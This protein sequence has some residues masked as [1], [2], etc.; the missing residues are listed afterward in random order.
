MFQNRLVSSD[1]SGHILQRGRSAG[2]WS[3]AGVAVVPSPGVATVAD[4]VA[5]NDD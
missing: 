4:D 2:D 1:K 3:P 5:L